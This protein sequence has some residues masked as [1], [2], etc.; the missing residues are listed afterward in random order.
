MNQGRPRL[1]HLRTTILI[2]VWAFSGFS[3]DADYSRERGETCE[4]S[5]AS[6][7]HKGYACTQTNA[8]MKCDEKTRTY[9][10]TRG[11]EGLFLTCDDDSH[12]VQG[13]LS[14]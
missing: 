2:F 7:G 11:F 4:L 5:D 12:E 9:R 3:C 10:D 13:I 6:T 14:F 8:L 1:H